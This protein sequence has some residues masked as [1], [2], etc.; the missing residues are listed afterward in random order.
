[1]AN[2]LYAVILML[3]KSVMVKVQGVPEKV[4]FFCKWY[5]QVSESDLNQTKL[6]L[7]VIMQWEIVKAA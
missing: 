4:C 2:I 7:L 6:W 1:M 5:F 3:I